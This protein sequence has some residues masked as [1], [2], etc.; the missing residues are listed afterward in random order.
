MHFDFHILLDAKLLIETLGYL[1][2][3]FAV[4]AESGL[5]FGVI[6]P[7]DTLLF[8]AGFLASQ[9][10]LNIFVLIGGIFAMAVL[11]DNFGYLTGKKLGPRIFTKEESFFFKQSYIEKAE[12]YFKKHGSKTIILARFIPFVR[13]FAPML[14]GVGSMPYKTFF[15]YN[16][17][18]S[19]VWI[20][21]M[22]LSGYF[23]G[24]IFP[25]FDHYIV[26]IAGG[27]FVA[28]F[29]PIIYKIIKS[30]K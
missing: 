14:A 1:G 4:F 26:Y 7:G 15:F 13:T 23:L 17:V 11:G 9:G 5:F 12:V 28:S 22:L 18:G 29:I 8:T 21:A 20:C 16:L 6:F 24:R 25:T 19:V 30:R 27:I 10:L 3:F 2:I